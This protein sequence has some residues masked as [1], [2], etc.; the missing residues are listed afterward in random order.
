MKYILCHVLAVRKPFILDLS[1]RKVSTLAL[2]KGQ[3]VK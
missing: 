2:K 1:F 3:E